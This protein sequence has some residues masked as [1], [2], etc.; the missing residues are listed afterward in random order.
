MKILRAETLGFCFGVRDAI[1]LAR[2]TAAHGPVTI[3]GDLVH[4]PDVM[5]DLG[6][7]GVTVTN[8]PPPAGGGTI[9]F[10]AHGVSD[11]RRAAVAAAGLTPVDATCPLVHR[12]H[13]ALAALVRRGFHPVVIGVRHHVEVRGFTEDWPECE[14]LLKPEDVEA[15]TPRPAFGVVAQTTQPPERV[16]ELVARLRA[17]FPSAHVELVDTVCSPTKRRQSAAR[18]LAGRC[19]V[20]VV[21]GGPKSNNTRE[22][23]AICEEACLRVHQVSGATELQE[24]WFFRD[25]TVGV[26]AGASTPDS[27]IEAVEARL[28]AMADTLPIAP[29]RGFRPHPAQSAQVAA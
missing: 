21:I 18:S 15:V 1:Q 14:V 13:E 29:S 22:L 27:S 2:Q 16:R 23:T 25:D 12:A 19:D 26:T 28:Q 8:D 7:L 6:R 24:A 5:A 10:T 20:V 3:L 11:R 17:R 4:N 9:M